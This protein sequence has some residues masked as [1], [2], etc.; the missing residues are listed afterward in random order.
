MSREPPDGQDPGLGQEEVPRLRELRKKRANKG[1]ILAGVEPRPG[2]CHAGKCGGGL[3]GGAE[4]LIHRQA[5]H[6]GAC[7]LSVTPGEDSAPRGG[8][9]EAQSDPCVDVCGIAHDFFV[10][11]P[12]RF[13]QHRQ[14]KA[15][16]DRTAGSGPHSRADEPRAR[17]APK[18]PRQGERLWLGAF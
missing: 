5:I 14:E 3:K 7:P 13:Q 2:L 9:A 6:D 10:E 4:R 12:N 15:I 16:D 18:D 8:K 1:A 17:P 11:H